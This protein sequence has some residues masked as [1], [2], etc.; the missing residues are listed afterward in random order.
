MYTPL[1]K[2]FQWVS[3][4]PETQPE[5]V[6]TVHKALFDLELTVSLT[7]PPTPLLQVHL[8]S[9]HGPLKF[10]EQIKF[11][12]VSQPLPLLLPV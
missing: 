8:P 7:S 2:M 3:L 11:I 12:S 6:P 4:A 5:H 10:L 9:Y 1:L